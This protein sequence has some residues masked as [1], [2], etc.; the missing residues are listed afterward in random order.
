[1]NKKGAKNIA[2]IFIILTFFQFSSPNVSAEKVSS[3]I[4]FYIERGGIY[5]NGD[6]NF[7][8]ENG[9]V[10]GDGTPENPYIIEGYRFVGKPIGQEP[11]TNIPLSYVCINGTNASF[12]IRHCTFGS[13]S[14]K[15][16]VSY[17]IYLAYTSNGVLENIETSELSIYSATNFVGC[18][19]SKNITIRNCTF[20]LPDSGHYPLAWL[21][22]GSLE[23]FSIFNNTFCGSSDPGNWSL[24]PI[25][26]HPNFNMKSLVLKHNR[27]I[28]AGIIFAPSDGRVNFYSTWDIDT[29]NTINGKPICFINSLTNSTISLDRKEIGQLIIANCTNV[30]LTGTFLNT[31]TRNAPFQILACYDCKIINNNFTNISWMEVNC[32]RVTFEYNWIEMQEDFHLISHGKGEDVWLFSN[33]TIICRK[34]PFI[35]GSGSFPRFDR[36]YWSIWHSPDADGD[37]I[38]DKPLMLGD[39]MLDGHPLSKFASHFDLFH[40]PL[41]TIDASSPFEIEGSVR[42][43]KNITRFIMYYKVS[44]ENNWK[45]TGESFQGINTTVYHFSFSVCVMAREGEVFEYYFAVTDETNTSLT[46]AHYT[47]KITGNKAISRSVYLDVII[48][49]IVSS[50]IFLGVV[51]MLR[52]VKRK[53]MKKIKTY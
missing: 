51:Y 48:F 30:T 35:A 13:D 31:S 19:E 36:N 3:D 53:K 25:I 27:F 34:V 8:K 29:T 11:E 43:T 16:Y 42:S 44:G 24:L 4:N 37:S 2:I 17:L 20:H 1:M 9:V 39:K 23:N 40:I 45:E 12:I 32:G 33:N 28:N 46:T 49:L 5:I 7:T 18:Y 15:F 14:E 50:V 52:K 10:S 26:I 38:V 6:E 22:I 47:A 41:I 21:D